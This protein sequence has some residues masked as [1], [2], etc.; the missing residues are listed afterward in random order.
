MGNRDCDV[1]PYSEPSQRLLCHSSGGVMSPGRP[2]GWGC[3]GALQ[4]ARF[5]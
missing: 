2:M 1:L 5:S 4:F 3:A